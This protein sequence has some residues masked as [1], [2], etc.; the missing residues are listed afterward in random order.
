MGLI[1][2]GI[3]QHATPRSGRVAQVVKLRE[4]KTEHQKLFARKFTF[5]LLVIF[6]G[7]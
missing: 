4:R 3:N 1:K 5:T 2:I 7:I 6:K